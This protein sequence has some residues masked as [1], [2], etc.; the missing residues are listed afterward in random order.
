[1]QLFHRASLKQK[2]MWIIMLTTGVALL[3]ACGA[4]TTYEVI[5]FRKSMVRNVSSMAELVGNSTSAALDF[6]DPRAA[7]ENL[8]ALESEPHIEAGCIYSKDGEVFVKYVR[9]DYKASFNPPAFQ[10]DA[11]YFADSHLNLFRPILSKGELIGVVYLKSD[12]ADL[13]SR[14]YQYAVIV[15]TVLLLTLGVA[16]VLSNHLQRLISQPI[17]HLVQTT[18][19][20]AADRNYSIRAAKT[21]EDELGVLIDGFNEMLGQIQTRDSALQAARDNLELRVQERTKALQREILERKRAEEAVLESKQ[22]YHSLVEHLPVCVFRKDKENRFVFVNA[23]F[24][25]LK[26]RNAEQILG[27]SPDEVSPD[28]ADDASN[29]H[30]MIM[31]TGKSIELEETYTEPDGSVRHFQ[32]VKSPVFAADGSVVGSQG[33]LLDITQRKQAEAE[34]AYERELLRSLLDR[35]PDHIYFKD[36]E[37]RFIRASRELAERFR[38]KPEQMIGKT[39]FDFF[40][41]EHARP[42]YEDEQEII[43]T[44]KPMIGKVEKEIVKDG[45][46]EFFVLTTKM[47]LRNRDGEIIGTFGISKDITGLKQAEARL[48]A[49]HRQLV[50]TSRMAGM[51]EVATSVLHNVGNV[52]NSVNV[53]GSVIGERIKKSKVSSLAKVAALFQEHAADL[54]AFFAGDPRGKQLPGYLSDLSARLVA[55]Q[56]EILN[57]LSS[58]TGNID[59]IKEIVTMQQSYARVAGVLENLALSELIEDALRL[60]AGAME[61]HQVRVIKE[62]TELPP[63][64]VDKHKVLQILVNLIRNAKYALD[65][66]MPAE[67]KLILRTCAAP[68]NRVRIAVIDN[69]IGIPAENLTRIFEHGFTTRKKGHGFGL[70]SGALTAREMGGSLIARSEGRGHGATF[71]LELPCNP[72]TRGNST[73]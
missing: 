59:H 63:M 69:G 18:R 34:L 68:E 26:G 47:P 73:N 49:A 46:G 17:L 45:A 4:I 2:Q 1:M 10:K 31:R 11:N 67:K 8:S 38:V 40:K 27:Q 43:R 16:F 35:S 3:L 71:I 30:E 32:V 14:L 36:R 57:E 55:E 33:M 52:L 48:E 22:L 72:A 41:E 65:E 12:L 13:Y 56:E 15:G 61:R 42:A 64:M 5:T 50:E 7:E 24:C 23:R 66:G 6:N 25:R 39:D 20:V 37:S 29:H 62:F 53:S 60:N 70:H 28:L 21:S 19:T 44:G 51:A 9:P 58:L 54:P